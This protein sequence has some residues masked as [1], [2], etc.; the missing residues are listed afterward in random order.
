MDAAGL[1]SLIFQHIKNKL[2]GHL[3]LVDEVANILDVSTDSAYRR[4]RG[5]KPMILEELY[6]L[7]I[8]FQISLDRFMNLQSD[9]FL[10]TGNIVNT[11]DFQYDSYLKS[12]LGN[13]KYISGFKERQM[14]YSCK[15][16]P[17][18]H[19]FHYKEI[20]AFKRYV[21]MKGIFASPEFAN[22]KFSL[23]DYSDE[24][25]ELGQKSLNIYNQA[26]SVE[27]WNIESINSSLR[28]IEFYH[29]S[30]MFSNEEEIVLIY[31]AFEKL[32]L[33]L[34]RQADL[35]Y[36]FLASDEQASPQGK[37]QMYFNEMVI[38]DNSVLAVLDGTKTA[39]IIHTVINIM[40]TRDIRFCDNLYD[41]MNHLMRC[42]TLISTV[43]E[44]ERS[45]FFKYLRGRI[46]ARKEKVGL[47]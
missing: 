12:V 10:F 21:W 29:E 37:Y 25:F 14:Y 36:K 7:C 40:V 24:L 26:N 39:F 33:H 17:I 44:R 23:A 1:Q 13:M 18:F 32:I 6:K 16:I 31:D 34:E 46:A 45:R 47:V 11:S 15:D 30:N 38:G 27:I 19:H 4:I 22:K 41:S 42:S 9:A 35:G 8:H 5:E 43:S 2:P 3:S 20:A 28:Q